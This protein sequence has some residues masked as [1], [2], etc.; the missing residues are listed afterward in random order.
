M[1]ERKRS[2]RV[3]SFIFCLLIFS[4]QIY[5][6]EHCTCTQ[7][8]PHKL[9]IFVLFV[10][11]YEHERLYEGSLGLAPRVPRF[12]SYP[13]VASPGPSAT[14]QVIENK[15]SKKSHLSLECMPTQNHLPSSFL[16]VSLLQAILFLE[17]R[18]VCTPRRYLKIEISESVQYIS[19]IQTPLNSLNHLNYTQRTQWDDTSIGQ[20]QTNQFY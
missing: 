11:R 18:G 20:I 19:L 14:S 6:Y 12:F 16:G 9:S 8:R 13:F 10:Y 17:V 3:R 2:Q 15:S 1:R 4:V 7:I 5:A